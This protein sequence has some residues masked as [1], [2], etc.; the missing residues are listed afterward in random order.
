MQKIW[1]DK[2]RRFYYY[3]T[4]KY[5]REK[6][7]E[8]PKDVIGYRVKEVKPGVKVLLAIRR[9]RGKRG[10]RTKAVALLRTWR[11]VARKGGVRALIQQSR[12]K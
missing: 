1:V 7:A 12:K 9:K 5:L 10:G 4:G 11:H 2:A 3:R 6:L 8:K